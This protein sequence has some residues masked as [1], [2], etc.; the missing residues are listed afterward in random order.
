[1]NA[2]AFGFVLDFFL[3]DELFQNLL[4]VERLEL[5]R[6]L[7]ALFDLGELLADFIGGNR[8][9]ADLGDRVDRGGVTGAGHARHEVEEHTAGQYEDDRAQKNAREQLLPIIR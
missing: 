8:F 1:V 2:K 4:G 3:E 6:N 9:V 7:I 5:L